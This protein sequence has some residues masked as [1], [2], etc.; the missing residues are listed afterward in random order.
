MIISFIS[1]KTPADKTLHAIYVIHQKSMTKI[2]ALGLCNAEA[3]AG[4]GILQVPDWAFDGRPKFG[5]A[6]VCPTCVN[7][8]QG[9][10]VPPK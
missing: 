6:S 5:E 3:D 9:A 2:S 4:A 1:S 8:V 10:K 7:H